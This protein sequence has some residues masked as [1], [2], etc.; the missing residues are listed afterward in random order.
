MSYDTD[1]KTLILNRIKKSDTMKERKKAVETERKIKER[2][3]KEKVLC[4][5][6]QKCEDNLHILNM[7]KDIYSMEDAI[8][9]TSLKIE[10][11]SNKTYDKQNEE[12]DMLRDDIMK[13]SIDYV[14]KKLVEEFPELDE[15]VDDD[16][17]FEN[18]IV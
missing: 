3:L 18:K 1:K 15:K 10:E 14:I 4:M 2:L 12:I 13:K 16:T 17:V 8:D 9:D 6:I 7:K 11:L 5:D